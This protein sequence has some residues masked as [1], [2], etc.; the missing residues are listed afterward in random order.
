MLRKHTA[1]DPIGYGIQRNFRRAYLRVRYTQKNFRHA[2]KYT[3]KN[4]RGGTAKGDYFA[5]LDALR[6][7]RSRHAGT[8]NP[9]SPK[10]PHILGCID[11]GSL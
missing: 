10:P 1:K 6:R 8:G 7:F 9:V 4:I 3:P 2:S 11:Q 5:A